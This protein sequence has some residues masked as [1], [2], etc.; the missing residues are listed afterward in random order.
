MIKSIDIKN[1]DEWNNIVKSFNGWDIYYTNEYA[2]SLMIHGDGIPQLLYWENGAKRICDVIIIEDVENSIRFKDKLKEGTYLDATTPY[3]YGGPL[4][5][6]VLSSVEMQLFLFELNEKL[7]EEN[8]VSQFVRF[9]PLI[10]LQRD[11]YNAFN[12]VTFKETVFIDTTDK[13]SIWE[14]M[15]S[16]N[17]NMIRKAIKSGVTIKHDKG[18]NIDTFIDIYNSTMDGHNAEGY[19]Y[20]EKKYYEFLIENMKDNIEFFYS[21]LDGKIIGTSIFF[22]ND[23]F[24]HYHLSGVYKEYKKY[25]S[26][27]LLLYEAANWANEHGIKKLHLGGGLNKGDSLF[28][29]KKKFNKHGIVPFYVGRMICDKVKYKELLDV[30]KKFDSTF[31]INNNYLIQYRK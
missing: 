20:F 9:H 28:K 12:A 27:N 22:F 26:T 8:I 7:K 21:Y 23:E 25:A 29:F 16:S 15:E 10:G 14:N 4:S 18:E 31:D 2:K 6:G 24:M 5:D 17:R 1:I 19:Y 11:F 13:K 30:R 3:G